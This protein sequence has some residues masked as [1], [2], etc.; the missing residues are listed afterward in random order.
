M[1]LTVFAGHATALVSPTPTLPY[2][3]MTPTLVSPS[4]GIAVSVTDPPIESLDVTIVCNIARR[5]QGS[6]IEWE[7]NLLPVDFLSEAHSEGRVD[8]ADE[9]SRSTLVIKRSVRCDAGLYSC[10]VDAECA[11]EYVEIAGRKDVGWLCFKQLQHT[12]RMGLESLGGYIN[13]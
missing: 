9:G 10:C 2:F 5:P 4:V 12:Y 6:V 13:L 7:Y 1:L 3:H 11:E 8:I